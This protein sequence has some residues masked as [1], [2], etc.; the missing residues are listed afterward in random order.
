MQENL[1]RTSRD[2]ASVV[3]GNSNSHPTTHKYSINC[4]I[5]YITVVFPY[6]IKDKYSFDT[7]YQEIYEDYKRHLPDISDIELFELIENDYPGIQPG[8]HYKKVT[9]DIEED[10]SGLWSLN[11]IKTSIIHW[12]KLKAFIPESSHYHIKGSSGYK[13]IHMFTNNIN[14]KSDGPE[15]NFLTASGVEKKF[16]TCSLE[17][18]GTGCR[19]LEELGVDLLEII[20]QFYLVPG[21]HITRIDNATDLL[22]D[23][24]ITMDW[25]KQKI[26]DEVSYI[27][28]F[29]SVY[30]PKGLYK[31]KTSDVGTKYHEEHGD[32]I[33]F[34]SRTSTSMLVI[35]DKLL[36]R[37]ENLGMPIDLKSWIRFELRCFGD[38]ADTLSK[39]LINEIS[40]KEFANFSKSLLYDH[41]DIKTNK[42]KDAYFRATR[43]HTWP[44]DP[45]W[46]D[47]MDRVNKVKIVSQNGFEA[48]FVKTRGWFDRAAM[49]TQATL[50][51]LYDDDERTLIDTLDREI[52]VLLDFKDDQLLALNQYRRK[53]YGISKE[54]TYVDI[55]NRIIKLQNQRD[56][57][58][59]KFNIIRG[60]NND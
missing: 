40:K 1:P 6:S 45:L 31:I 46:A 44:T 26:F 50:N 60:D 39:K 35:Y 43:Q 17:I 9:D 3:G 37:E 4:C 16:K 47:F 11:K 20:K 22:N 51:L 7:S 48:D 18:S 59:K 34:G 55:G 21:C 30:K 25:L 52:E 14:F 33:E 57:L 56:E 28:K 19:Q 42:I 41:L 53:S 27:S 32:S 58:I 49:T 15:M 36:E 8:I 24:F 13:F 54:I 29:K 12:C 5:D 2:M 23:D 38:K 10:N